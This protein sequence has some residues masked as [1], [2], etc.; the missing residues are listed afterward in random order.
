MRSDRPFLALIACV[1]LSAFLSAA[2]SASHGPPSSTPSDSAP[3]PTTAPADA[4]MQ[5]AVDAL[6]ETI[7]RY[8]GTVGVQVVDVASGRVLASHEADKP[9]NP[10][11]NMKIVTAAASLWKLGANH[12]YPTA[13]Y[14]TR[15]GSDVGDLVLRGYGDPSLTTKDLWEL[16]RGLHREGVRK[17]TGDILV[18][19]SYFDDAYVPPGFEQQPN[20]WAYFRAPVSAV[21]LERNTV[22][23][24]VKPTRAGERALVTFVPPGFVD[25]AGSVTTKASGS[26]QSVTLTVEGRDGRLRAVVGG[27]IPEDSARLRLD[28]RIDD[29]TLYA[30]HVLRA[31]LEQ[32]GIE[33][34]GR[35]RQGGAKARARIA[36]VLSNPLAEL[37]PQLGKES[38][39]FYAEMIFKGL[40]G[41]KKRR[42][43]TSEQGAEV[44]REYLAHVGANT[45]GVVI[46]NGSGLFDTNRLT[47]S[48]IAAVLRAS[49]RDGAVQPEFVSQLAV[50]G[51]DGTLRWRFRKGHER[52]NVRAKT[53]TL[54]S[55][56]SL[57]GYVMAPEERSPIAF[58][59][60]VNG[61]AGKVPGA[62]VAI[63]KCVGRFV[64]QVWAD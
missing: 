42:G 59:I 63:D 23:L 13:L 19:Q 39:N 43:L 24:N 47:A 7:Q 55:V 51:K 56:T 15:K 5:A 58:S 36:L 3:S 52:G 10:A 64:R 25:V 57:S 41:N 54:A 12:R 33:V 1:A 18:D 40:A 26:A 16:T 6:A 31:L 60:M 49:Y 17:V 22:T 38:D 53:G 45:E 27:S 2:P 14:G 46:R 50:G 30:G 9:L 62:R 61:V 20:E 34:Q 35:V 32:Q 48:T 37:L 44:V 11:S 21:A 28:K 8:G 4:A 29:P